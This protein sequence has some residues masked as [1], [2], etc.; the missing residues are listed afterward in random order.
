M[1]GVQGVHVDSKDK[2]L[3]VCFFSIIIIFL[4][5]FRERNLK[6]A[7]LFR[8]INAMAA[9]NAQYKIQVIIF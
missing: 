2:V 8:Y 4:F 7:F 5:V 6:D 1:C 3:S 9:Q